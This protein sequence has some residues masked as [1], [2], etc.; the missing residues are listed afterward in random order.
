MPTTSWSPL[1]LTSQMFLLCL[2]SVSFHSQ[3]VRS[4]LCAQLLCS[5]LD[6]L[7][8]SRFLQVRACPSSFM[9]RSFLSVLILAGGKVCFFVL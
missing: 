8:S 1:F 2:F 5:R 4:L 9:R 7:H 6:L 3:V